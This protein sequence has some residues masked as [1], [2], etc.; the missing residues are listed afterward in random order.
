[1]V[2]GP[3][4]PGFEVVFTLLPLILIGSMVYIVLSLAQR[5]G[6]PPPAEPADAPNPALRTMYT[7]AL[8]VLVAAFVGFGIEVVYPAPEFPERELFDEPGG[9]PPEMIV[10][11]TVPLQ[12]SEGKAK[13]PPLKRPSEFEPEFQEY[14]QELAEHNR[15]GSVIALGASVL[16]W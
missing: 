9:T 7:L 6:V 10:E 2:E 15:I 11:E 1:M 8:G 13:E 5:R 12:Q 3:V 14:Q 4:E 16:I